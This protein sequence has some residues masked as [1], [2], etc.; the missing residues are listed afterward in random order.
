MVWSDYLEKERENSKEGGGFNQNWCLGVWK[1]LWNIQVP[2]ATKVF[3]WRACNN[4]LLV[5][6]NL[7]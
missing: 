5:K 7:K 4:I 3:L 1:N 2:N 6:D